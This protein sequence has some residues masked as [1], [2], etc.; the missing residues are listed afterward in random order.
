MRAF[1]FVGPLATITLLTALPASAAEGDLSL[2]ASSSGASADANASGGGD[3]SP[4]GESYWEGNR[5]TSMA[6]ELGVYGGLAMFSKE[7]NLQNL[8]T[9]PD[10]QGHQEL[11]LSPDLGFRLGFYPAEFLGV[12]G[13]LGGIW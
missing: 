7:H 13:E 10:A 8:A 12:E 4:G 1:S 2:S 6:L 3:S 11:K 9:I 5:P